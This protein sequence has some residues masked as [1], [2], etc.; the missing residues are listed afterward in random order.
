MNACGCTHIYIYRCVCGLHDHGVQFVVCMQKLTTTLVT[1]G[2]MLDFGAGTQSAKVIA[3]CLGLYYVPLDLKSYEHHAKNV[4]FDLSI[5]YANVLLM[6]LHIRTAVLEQ[7]NVRL[8][9][10]LGTVKFIWLSPPCRTFSC[11]DAVNRAKGFGYRDF[12]QIARPPLQPAESRYG[13]IARADDSLA[14]YW[15][16]LVTMWAKLH[17]PMRWILENPIGS[18]EKRPYMRLVSALSKSTQM[19][20]VHYCAYGKEYKKPTRLWTNI[21]WRP[22][23]NSGNGLCAGAG[24]CPAMHGQKHKLVVAGGR[25]RQMKGIGTTAMKSLVPHALFVEIT[26]ALR[27]DWCKFHRAIRRRRVCRQF[28]QLRQLDSR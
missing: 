3:S 15:V 25:N 21:M 6:W 18:L 5:K 14:C 19:Q 11:M 22:I 9:P 27:C 23:G 20:T 13:R 2:V 24:M 26:R 10:A 8:L 28:S 7:L 16:Q 4:L 12:S 1:Q 17:A